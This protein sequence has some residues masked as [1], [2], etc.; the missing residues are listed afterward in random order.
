MPAI[1]RWAGHMEPC[2]IENWT[3]DQARPRK[4]AVLSLCGLR[5]RPTATAGKAESKTTPE[6]SS[7][8]DPDLTGW[9][10]LLQSGAICQV[11]RRQERFV[12]CCCN[13]PQVSSSSF[14]AFPFCLFLD[15]FFFLQPWSYF[16]RT[17]DWNCG[18]D[19]LCPR[20]ECQCTLYF[21]VWNTLSSNFSPS[22][23]SNRISPAGLHSSPNLPIPG[24]DWGPFSQSA[25]WNC[26]PQKAPLCLPCASSTAPKHCIAASL[27][28]C[29]AAPLHHCISS[30]HSP[31]SASKQQLHCT[32]RHRFLRAHHS[33]SQTD[34]DLRCTAYGTLSLA[35][36]HP[37]EAKQVPSP[38]RSCS[39]TSQPLAATAGYHLHHTRKPWTGLSIRPSAAAEKRA[40]YHSTATHYHIT[41]RSTYYVQHNTT[42]YATLSAFP[43]SHPIFPF[44]TLH[45]IS[46]SFFTNKQTQHS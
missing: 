25:S 20:S 34:A 13:S 27:H 30:K 3:G 16:P 2:E 9:R 31:A 4:K 42:Q 45:D 23:A 28:R 10:K 41:L 36:F 17:E 19:P 21:K 14:P 7:R 33:H 1:G 32:L 38:E 22:G 35:H 26:S 12:R 40:H 5:L 24:L 6:P 37:T 18:G 43:T 46:L 29:I 8:P 39:V 44:L 11:F 15:F